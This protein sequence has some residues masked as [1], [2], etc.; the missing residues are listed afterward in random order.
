MHAVA[1]QARNQLVTNDPATERVAT[2]WDVPGVEE[3]H[4][5]AL[6]EPRRRA[7]VTGEGNTTMTVMDLRTMKVV[8]R[9]QV[10]A[11]P[12]VLAWDA[13]W[14]RLYVAS[15]SGTLT[16]PST[17]GDTLRALG[18][19]RAPHAHSVAVDARTY[20]VYLPLQNAGGRP[21]LRILQAERRG[22]PP[23][24]LRPVA[25][26]RCGVHWHRSNT[27]VSSARRR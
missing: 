23:R 26:N 7:S 4:G 13:E 16:F 21:V 27:A 14:Q 17:A 10:G 1:V 9:L 24:W 5:P 11:N 12:D 3:L 19:L 15:E 25:V 22:V 18:E 8:Q 2:R 20:R 6:D